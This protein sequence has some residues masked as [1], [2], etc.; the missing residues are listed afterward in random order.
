MGQTQRGPHLTHHNQTV[1]TQGQILK[2]AR[3]KWLVK[4]KGSSMRLTADFSS[5]AIVSRRQ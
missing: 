3:D 1:I 5:K 4:F 2:I